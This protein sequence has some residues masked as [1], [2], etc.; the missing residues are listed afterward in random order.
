[1]DAHELGLV[2]MKHWRLAYGMLSTFGA[3]RLQRVTAVSQGS[4]GNF[5]RTHPFGHAVPLS[6][7]Y[8]DEGTLTLAAAA[9]ACGKHADR[10]N[11][12]ACFPQA[13]SV[14]ANSKCAFIPITQG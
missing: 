12:S 8:W 6:L 1:M 4:S 13:S 14:A 5:A 11:R 10:Q 2:K 7:R 3:L 9:L